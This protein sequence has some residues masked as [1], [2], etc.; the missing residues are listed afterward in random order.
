MGTMTNVVCPDKMPLEGSIS[1]GSAL[2]AFSDS[3][4]TILTLKAPITTA[5]AN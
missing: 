5:A 4:S 1:S 2:F 3:N